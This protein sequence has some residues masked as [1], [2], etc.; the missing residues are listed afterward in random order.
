[1]SVIEQENA[2]NSKYDKLKA[3]IE[4]KEVTDGYTQA[5]KDKEIAE[6]EAKEITDE[7]TQADK[8]KEIAAVQAKQ[9]I[10][11]Y[12][13][14]MKENELAANEAAREA[15]LKKVDD[16]FENQLNNM[17]NKGS[18]GFSNDYI[19]TVIENLDFSTPD[20]VEIDNDTIETMMYSLAQIADN[21]KFVYLTMP[22]KYTALN[23]LSE[24]EYSKY[25]ST[26]DSIVNKYDELKTTIEAK[27]LIDGYTQEDKDKE[28]AEIEAKEITDEY[29]QED[30]DK[31]ITAIEAKEITDEYTEE[32]KQNELAD[33][34][35]ARDA[36]IK[37]L[38]EEYLNTMTTIGIAL[39]AL[40]TDNETGFA[41]D[42]HIN[43]KLHVDEDVNLE[44]KLNNISIDDILTQK[45]LK[46]INE[47]ISTKADSEH[48]HE[49]DDIFG[50]TDIKDDIYMMLESHGSSISELK[51]STSQ[52][53]TDISN[54]ATSI[55]NIES[56]IKTINESISSKADSS[57]NHTLSDITD[58]EQYDDTELK[59]SI[60]SNTTSI[61]TIESNIKTINTS[62]T[63][64]VD[65]TKITTYCRIATRSQRWAN[66]NKYSYDIIGYIKPANRTYTQISGNIKVTILSTSSR[67]ELFETNIIYQAGGGAHKN[68][69]LNGNSL[70]SNTEGR[71][72]I[73]INPVD[74]EKSAYS[75]AVV[76]TGYT[77]VDSCGYTI[78]AM[79]PEMLKLYSD[80]AC[81]KEQSTNVYNISQ[82]N[83]G[84]GFISKD[85]LTYSSIYWNE[86]TRA[87]KTHS[88]TLSDIT[89]FNE[90]ET[91]D[92][93]ELRDLIDTK[94]SEIN[95]T[96]TNK[97]DLEHNHSIEDITD[98]EQYDDTDLKTSISNNATKITNIETNIKTINESLSNK[99][100]SSH[101]HSVEDITGLGEAITDIN[102]KL[103]TDETDIASN[104]SSISQLK[105]DTENIYSELVDYK[106]SNA[107]S[108]TNL[109]TEF[110]TLVGDIDSR[111]TSAE[112]TLSN[113]AD[114]EHKHKMTDIEDY[115]TV[116]LDF[117]YPVG[118]IYTSMNNTSPATLFGGNWNQII[119]RFLYCSN[120]SKTTGGSKKITVD[121]LPSHN[122]E[123]CITYKTAVDTDGN[124]DGAADSGN[125]RGYWRYGTTF[126]ESGGE[127]YNAGKG[128]DYMPPYITVFAWYRT[129]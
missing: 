81:T 122:H 67:S 115:K 106:A 45:H 31:E 126:A 118:S 69:I 6:I 55:T 54:N 70:I 96:L 34:E 62:L 108:L 24:T 107:K 29:T 117:I 56:N 73:L 13:K 26:Y 57:H 86:E 40:K 3:E 129:E 93:S 36:E 1:M 15:E 77:N 39:T 59:A 111:L 46:T 27:E 102:S 120:S 119:D 28:I 51:T 100:D 42:V 63:N 14:E 49:I 109:E 52:L 98:F 75:I 78:V 20:P 110:Q 116:L 22:T 82:S 124:P 33:N 41:G 58:F 104:K 85:S 60:A 84:F 105:T 103:N 12:T 71:S 11:A 16:D 76:I 72:G 66:T 121:N 18:S 53:K 2:I 68:F 17:L 32:M 47:T 123:F 80:S 88:H 4:A 19:N 95:T 61:T 8:D 92:D 79:M 65:K 99:A 44:G 113:K 38:N 21:C 30:K 64:K 10:T 50:L 23:E 125:N 35:T 7:Y 90:A 37:T 114:S 74:D 112:T 5:D 48:E 94:V 128:T 91:Y 9:L 87:N 127:T 43:G 83:G 97:A 89:D 25:A 101:N